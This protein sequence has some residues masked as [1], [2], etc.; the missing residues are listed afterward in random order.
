MK[1]KM[2]L[3]KSE[4][5]N[6]LDKIAHIF[7]RFGKAY[8]HYLSSKEYSSLVEAAFYINQI[9]SGFERIFKNISNVFENK[10]NELSWHQSLIDRMTLPLEGIR[11][12]VI[13]NETRS[14][15]DDLRGFRHFFRHAYNTDI[16]PKK[17]SI[18]ADST[19]KLKEQYKIEIQKFIDFINRLIED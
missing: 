8:D 10:I 13:S 18:V 11:P 12:A 7:N 19:L 14:M 5:L 4:I 9:Y 16:D 6:D 15:L 17:F 2:L 3:L 1:E